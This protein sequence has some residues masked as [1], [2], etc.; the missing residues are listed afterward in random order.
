MTVYCSALCSAADESGLRH[1]LLCR[2]I[3]GKTELVSPDSKQVL[4]SSD[5]LDCGVDDPLNPRRY[6]I[7]SA[8]MNSHICPLYIVSFKAPLPCLRSKSPQR[9]S[10]HKL[11]RSLHPSKMALTVKCNEELRGSMISPPASA[12]N[13]KA[14]DDQ[15]SSSL[16]KTSKDEFPY[17]SQSSHILLKWLPMLNT[18]R[19][20]EQLWL[21]HR[22][23]KLKP[24]NICFPAQCLISL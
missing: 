2:V 18:T 20:F 12:V 5:K 10:V 22:R 21:A 8:L 11:A 1:I 6:I 14:E 7:L 4:P 19:K 23:Q 17:Y 16:L 9:M 13:K 3:L 15:L 24:R